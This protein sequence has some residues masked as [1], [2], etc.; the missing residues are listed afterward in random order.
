MNFKRKLRIVVGGTRIVILYK[1]KVYKIAR[2]R[3]CKPLVKCILYSISLTGIVINEPSVNRA[4]MSN[5][6]MQNLHKLI[7]WVFYLGIEANLNEWRRWNDTHSEELVP[8]L[9]CFFGVLNVQMRAEQA[10]EL[11]GSLVQKAHPDRMLD[12]Y[13][14][15]DYPDNRGYFTDPDTK[16][17]NLRWLD[18]GYPVFHFQQQ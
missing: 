16:K 11:N 13:D 6:K 5:T 3:V 2:L 7:K 9:Y 17:R 10:R 4:L 8:T 14:D 1:S 18:Y 15:D 12:E